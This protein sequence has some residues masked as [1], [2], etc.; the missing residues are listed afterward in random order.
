MRNL[1]GNRQQLRAK[2]LSLGGAALAADPSGALYWPAERT[3]I[4]ADLHL[5]KGSYFASRGQ[6]LPP[7]DSTA[8]LNALGSAIAYYEPARVIAL[9]DSF[10]D[11]LGAERLSQDSRNAIS[12]MQQE[13]D[14]I[15][16]SGN[17]D[18]GRIDG[19]GGEF[20]ESLALGPLTFRHHPGTQA[21]EVVGHFHP[22]A[23]VSV[24]GRSMRRRC[25]AGSNSRLVMPA[26]GAFTG[27]FNIRNDVFREFF[28]TDFL[29]H[30]LGSER[31]Y[32]FAAADCLAD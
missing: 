11:Q 14:W 29:A 23:R 10:H 18:P 22:M 2:E 24:R 16:I 15:W 4:V 27:G 9:G 8:T 13:R 3:L 12:V 6:M 1:N 30:L 28:G 26:F 5:E 17:H 32:S 19:I 31:L 25:F 21:N 20:A 7:Y